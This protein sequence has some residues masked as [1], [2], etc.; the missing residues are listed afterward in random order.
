MKK[1]SSIFGL[2]VFGILLSVIYSG[3]GG[4]EP[5]RGS[6]QENLGE[7]MVMVTVADLERLLAEGNW[8]AVDHATALGTSAFPALEEAMNM[9]DYRSRQIA[10]VCAG[11]IGGEAAGHILGRGLSDVNV[12]VRLAAAGQLSM[13]PPE[14]VKDTLLDTLSE[15][16][17]TDIQEM[18]ALGAGYLPGERTVG[19]L[20]SLTSES[21][22]VSKS[23]TMALAKLGDTDAK[24][25]IIE[26]LSAEE[27]GVRYETLAA[28]RYIND[29]ELAEHA[30]NLLSDKAN[31]KLVGPQRRRLYRRVCDQAVD[32][33]VYLLKISLPFE[34]GPEKIYSD[35]ELA[36]VRAGSR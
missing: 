32:T 4:A 36:Q 20:K 18:L 16:G 9:P 30:R 28:L 5:T 35:E 8:S 7:D 12:N 23:A 2:V 25:Q 27:A 24:R 14:T 6:R 15:G 21:G 11:R 22:P 31:A 17:E 10:V 26:N 34:T 3:C 13:N 29:V 1:H 33:L 19:I